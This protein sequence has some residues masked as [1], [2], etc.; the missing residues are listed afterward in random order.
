MSK[1]WLENV[2]SYA[3]VK[4][5]LE[6]TQASYKKQANKIQRHIEFR[7]SDF[8]WLNIQDFKMFEAFTSQLLM[9]KLI[10]DQ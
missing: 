4:L 7:I 9:G 1:K 10:Q 2:K 6:K 5:F 8:I 3:R